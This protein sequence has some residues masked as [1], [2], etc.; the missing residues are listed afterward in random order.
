M[1]PHD[2]HLDSPTALC[3]ARWPGSHP[4]SYTPSCLT[5]LAYETKRRREEPLGRLDNSGYRRG[6]FG[7]FDVCASEPTT[8]WL[9]AVVRTVPRR[10]PAAQDSPNLG[11]LYCF[12]PFDMRFAVASPA[13]IMVLENKT[14]ED[15]IVLDH[16]REDGGNDGGL[17]K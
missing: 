17:E 3:M 4:Q 8:P 2:T 5:R 13:R 15:V 7:R 10:L 11:H 12:L 1:Q 14:Y 6:S 9:T 16:L